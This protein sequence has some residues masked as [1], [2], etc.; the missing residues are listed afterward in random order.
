MIFKLKSVKLV[1]LRRKV[2]NDKDNNKEKLFFILSSQIRKN[3]L[4]I[5]ND[6]T[7]RSV[8]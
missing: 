5:Y 1:Y 8:I 2:F 4:V 6:D 3:I 7:E